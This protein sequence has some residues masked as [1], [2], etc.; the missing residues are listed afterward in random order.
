MTDEA[1]MLLTEKEINKFLKKTLD[2]YLQLKKAKREELAVEVL[3]TGSVMAKSLMTL[4]G[5]KSKKV[6]C[7]RCGR[8]LR[9]GCDVEYY[10]RYGFCLSCDHILSD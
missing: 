3:R 2:T 6:V 4:A 7:G 8:I 10:N 9:E 1:R 5:I